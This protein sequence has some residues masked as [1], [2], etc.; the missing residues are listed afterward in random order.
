MPSPSEPRPTQYFSD[1]P[2][3]AS[4]RRTVALDLPDLSLA[5][6]TDRGVFSA[7][8]VDAGSKLLLLE[9]PA[10]VAG[11]RVLV[12]VGAGYGPIACTLARRNPAATI[13]AVEINERAR[14]LCATN[15]AANGLDNVRVIGPDDIPADLVVDRLWS[16]PPIRVGKAALHELLTGWLERLAPD[17]SAHLVVQ[18]HLGADSLVDWLGGQG[19]RAERRSSRKAFRLIDVTRPSRPSPPS[20]TPNR[21][22]P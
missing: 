17:G 12:D 9:G 13:Y 16:N 4:A 8:R 6:T 2:Q 19:Y 10:A 7:D 21:E 3:V 18:K 22:H 14:E 11:D 1:S 20:A 15:A 5:L